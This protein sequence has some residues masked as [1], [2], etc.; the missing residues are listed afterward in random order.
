MPLWDNKIVQE[1][2]SQPRVE[3]VTTIGTLLAVELKVPAGGQGGYG[4]T[5]AKA[6]VS[7]LRS[8]GVYTR[9][10]GNVVYIMCTP[11]TPKAVCTQLLKKLAAQL[12]LP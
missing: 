7:Q 6:I 5:A 8:S 9:P 1:L 10:L 4:S 3:G 12:G 2:S 11:T